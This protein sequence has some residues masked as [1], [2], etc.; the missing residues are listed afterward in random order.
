MPIGP[1]CSRPG[2]LQLVLNVMAAFGSGASCRSAQAEITT[3][4]GN[5]P[6]AR[7]LCSGDCKAR[8]GANGSACGVATS[9]SRTK[10]H[11][12]PGDMCSPTF[13]GITCLK[14]TGETDFA[15]SR[16]ELAM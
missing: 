15:P 12:G 7:N 11:Y 14:L 9:F 3:Q 5:N 1:P 13:S 8:I 4:V 6:H 2:R 10:V 16:C